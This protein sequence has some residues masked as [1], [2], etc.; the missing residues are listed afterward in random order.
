MKRLQVGDVIAS[1]KFAKLTR[2]Y[3]GER[4]VVNGSPEIIRDG[5]T[6]DL[7]AFDPTAPPPSSLSPAHTWAAAGMATAPATSTRTVGKSWPNA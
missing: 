2:S 3:D 7:L 1:P 4:L 6:V 5:E